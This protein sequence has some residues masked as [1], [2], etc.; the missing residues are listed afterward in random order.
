MK[1]QDRG[2]TLLEV[3]FSMIIFAIAS[4]SLVGV[5]GIAKRDQQAA[6]Q[7]QVFRDNLEIANAFRRWAANVNNGRLPDPYS[8]GR[9]HTLA[10][11]NLIP[12]SSE[13][14]L[15]VLL[16]YLASG[17]MSSRNYNSDGTT[18]EQ[19]KVYQKITHLSFAQPINGVSGETV[20]LLYDRGVIYQ[21]TCSKYAP[22]NSG[23]VGSSPVY[24]ASNWESV[25]PDLKPVEFSTLD[26]QQKLWGDTWTQMKEL[27]F[28]IRQ[29]YS[30]SILA[31]TAGD[32]TNHFFVPSS[33]GI[34]KGK[35]NCATAWYSLE[36]T[37][38][39]EHYGLIPK[40]IY[41]K[42]AW[43]GEID[44]CPDF[45]P[46]GLGE[47]APPHHAAIRINKNV[48][49]GIAPDNSTVNTFVLAI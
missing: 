5:L 2:F 39:L 31:A 30:S 8:D 13:P 49:Q 27:R 15:L 42:T 29:A 44:Y 41:G 12:S 14:N 20:T 36:T 25:F 21:T 35:L 43:G 45:D 38:A 16:D 34:D 28:K 24:T 9:T 4:S 37:D 19:A 33:G 47:N 46:L 7:N 32:T 17:R 10:P 22:C 6:Y 23:L 26:I 1:K 48:T 18:A 11:V 40:N 3:L